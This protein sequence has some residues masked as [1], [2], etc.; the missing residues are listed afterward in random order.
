MDAS[1]PQS[2][3]LPVA[4]PPLQ[5]NS[6]TTR[7][8]EPE[9]I[10][11]QQH[12]IDGV[13]VS[14]GCGAKVESVAL[15][16]DYSTVQ[17]SGLRTGNPKGEVRAFLKRLDYPQ[18]P[19][20]IKTKQIN[21]LPPKYEY[22][23][24]I[25]VLGT[26]AF[27]KVK[28]PKFADEVL[29]RSFGVE[30]YYLV[31]PSDVT[32]EDG[33]HQTSNVIFSWYTTGRSASIICPSI[34]DAEKTKRHIDS[35][36]GLHARHIVAIRR[37]NIL[38]ISN[39][40]PEWTYQDLRALSTLPGELHRPMVQFHD[41]IDLSSPEIIGFVIAELEACLQGVFHFWKSTMVEDRIVAV[42]RLDSFDTAKR[43]VKEMDG[44]TIANTGSFLDVR[45]FFLLNYKCEERIAC[46][47]LAEFALLD[48]AT[49]RCQGS[50]CAKKLG[51]GL[52]DVY[53]RGEANV[54][55]TLRH[56]KARFEK[57]LIGTTVIDSDSGEPLWY[58][59]MASVPCE[60]FTTK[61]QD[62]NNNNLVMVLKH[63]RAECVTVHGI[64]E[65][66][67]NKVDN[68]RAW[69]TRPAAFRYGLDLK[70]ETRDKALSRTRHIF[71]HDGKHILPH[72]NHSLRVVGAKLTGHVWLAWNDYLSNPEWDTGATCAICRDVA[73]HPLG[74]PCRHVYC[75]ECLVHQALTALRSIDL[76]PSSFPIIC[77]G[78]VEKCKKPL[79]LSFLHR[80]LG[81]HIMKKLLKQG[82]LEHIALNT[83]TIWP[84]PAPD[85]TAFYRPTMMPNPPTHVC[86]TCLTR[87][88]TTC[89]A[90]HPATIMTASGK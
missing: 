61:H 47:L 58:P 6:P 13:I 42:T 78:Q 81:G 73:I 68:I 59:W 90:S 41:N 56:I 57:A 77:W 25:V 45:Q 74:T 18:L 53:L 88:C 64:L 7:E 32:D 33:Q 63:N 27:V 21:T 5:S 83:G 82:L 55:N 14:F 29:R 17:I 40:K 48:E 15:P 31:R 2:T 26:T 35:R 43:I 62:A 54:L 71:V 38:K 22:S 52:M 46:T 11:L 70:G 84:C 1:I 10:P 39:L 3:Q 76:K 30:H 72:G 12:T 65:A 23:T 79:P 51:G 69:A 8:S 75:R 19:F 36:N 16:C 87:I 67:Q 24:E 50:V 89:D 85:C 34:A 37:E 44:F 60:L 49:Q 66:V 80:Y 86:P 9:I 20:E 4:A 28:D